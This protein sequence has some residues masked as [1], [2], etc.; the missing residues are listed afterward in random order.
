MSRILHI[1]CI[2][3]VLVAFCVLLT[4]NIRSI[5]FLHCQCSCT[6]LSYG[7]YVLNNNEYHLI[8]LR[9]DLMKSGHALMLVLHFDF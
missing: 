1:G 8:V 5:E 6:R 9:L 2:L 3:C 7:H 4:A